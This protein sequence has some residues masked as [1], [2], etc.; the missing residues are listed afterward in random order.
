MDDSLQR[1]VHDAIG[2]G[3]SR[4]EIEKTLVAA[5]WSSD[6]IRGALDLYAEIEFPIPVPRPQPY[7]SAGEAFVYLVMFTMLYLSAW[8]LGSVVFDFINRAIPDPATSLGSALRRASQLRWAV[9]TLLISFPG[10]M[11]L[12][13]HTFVA[14]RRDPERRKSKIRKWLTYLTLFLAASVIVGDLITLV[15]NLLEGELTSRFILKVLTVALVAGSIFGYYFWDLRQDDKNAAEIMEK[16]PRLRVFVW[17]VCGVVLISLAGGLYNAGTPASAR[18]QAIDRTREQH[19]ARIADKID[20]F[21]TREGRLPS[22]LPELDQTR[23]IQLQS[24]TDPESGEMYAYTITG[25]SAYELCAVFESSSTRSTERSGQRRATFW[26][27]PA[28]RHCFS[29]EAQDRD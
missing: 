25:E 12:S 1:F 16:N 7:L 4:E 10:Y 19:L 2:R 24:I 14:T 20:V 9:A 3:I 23:G 29:I 17:T 13:R 21:W 22:D 5:K 26:K 8:S 28:G 6:E 15:F 27:H 18:Q 11:L